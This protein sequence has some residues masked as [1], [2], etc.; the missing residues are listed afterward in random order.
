[1]YCDASWG[2]ALIVLHI[3]RVAGFALVGRSLGNPSAADKARR[4]K[5]PSPPFQ[6]WGI[7]GRKKEESRQGRKSVSDPAAVFF[8][9][10]GA[11]SCLETL[12]PPLKRWARIDRPDGTI[13][14]RCRT[15]RAEPPS[16]PKPDEPQFAVPGEIGGESLTGRGREHRLAAIRRLC[17]INRHART[18]QAS[19]R[20]VSR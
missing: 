4:A 8:R 2:R 10:S 9:P 18:F 15:T 20:K 14:T 16:M 11:R 5:D 17:S 12:Y 19:K 1:M 13:G 7:G 3:S 6:R